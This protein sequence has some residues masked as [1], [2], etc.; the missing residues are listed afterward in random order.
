MPNQ[1]EAE[2]RQYWTSTG[3]LCRTAD[4]NVIPGLGCCC[5][6]LVFYCGRGVSSLWP[7]DVSDACCSGAPHDGQ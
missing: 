3:R 2:N 4:K 5:Y 7:D 1:F 6:V